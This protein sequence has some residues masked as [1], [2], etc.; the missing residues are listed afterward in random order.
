MHLDPKEKLLLTYHEATA[1]LGICET[2]LRKEVDDGR[3][4]T[5][6][7]GK[8]GVRFAIEELYRWRAERAKGRQDQE[9]ESA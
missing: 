7:V 2:S 6:P 1:L 3:I 8:R 5:V 4:S 9:G